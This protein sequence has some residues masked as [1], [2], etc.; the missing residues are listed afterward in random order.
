MSAADFSGVNIRKAPGTEFPVT[1]P[2]DRAWHH[3]AGIP[4]VPNPPDVVSGV[5]RIPDQSQPEI[6]WHFFEC[7]PHLEGV[8][9][10]FQ[11]ADVKEIPVLRQSQTLEYLACFRRFG[12][13][14]V[15]DKCADRVVLPKIVVLNGP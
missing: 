12:I 9:L 13:G 4:G 8:I 1:L 6:R 2:V 5:W 7:L 11:A 10:R 15:R 3:D 14:A